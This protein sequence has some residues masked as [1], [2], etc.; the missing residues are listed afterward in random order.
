GNRQQALKT[1]QSGLDYAQ[2]CLQQGEQDKQVWQR[3]LRLQESYTAHFE[4][5]QQVNQQSF[6]LASLGFWL[7]MMAG[8]TDV[9]NNNIV[10]HNLNIHSDTNIDKP[11]FVNGIQNL[12][13]NMIQKWHDPEKNQRLF[14]SIPTET[15]LS[16]AESIYILEQAKTKQPLSE[17]YQTLENVANSPFIQKALQCR[18]LSEQ[19]YQQLALQLEQ[20]FPKKPALWQPQRK[21]Y[22][23]QQKQLHDYRVQLDMCEGLE[24]EPQ[25]QNQVNDTIQAL[26]LWLKK[27][28]KQRFPKFTNSIDDPHHALLAILFI[29]TPNPIQQWQT[30][31]CWH[32][33]NQCS[34]SLNETR[35]ESWIKQNEPDFFSWQIL[36]NI[37]PISKQALFKRLKL[38]QNLEYFEQDELIK[39]LQQLQQGNIQPL[40]QQLDN[41]WRELQEQAAELQQLLDLLHEDKDNYQIL[42]TALILGDAQTIIYQQIAQ[43]WQ[44]QGFIEQ[45]DKQFSAEILDVYQALQQRFQSATSLYETVYPE[46]ALWVEC[47]AKVHFQELLQQ[48]NPDTNQ[49]WNALERSR[50]SLRHVHFELEK[51]W[52]EN[53]GHDLWVITRK[54][55]KQVRAEVETAQSGLFDSDIPQTLFPPIQYWLQCFQTPIASIEECQQQLK[56][57]QAIIQPFIDESRQILRLL[58]LDKQSLKIYD[59][60]NSQHAQQWQKLIDQWQHNWQSVLDDER[61]NSLADDIQHWA[62]DFEHLIAIFPTP[63]GQLAWEAMPQLANKLSREISIDHWLHCPKSTTNNNN[64]VL[65]VIDT[66]AMQSAHFIPHETCLVAKHWNTQPTLI[67]QQPLALFQALQNL[68]QHRKIFISTHGVFNS[69]DPLKS[70]L[71]LLNTSNKQDETKNN[72]DLP[73]W[74][75][76]SLRLDDTELMIL[77]ACQTASTPSAASN[78]FDPISI[79]STFAAAGVNTVIATLSKIDNIA[80]LIFIDDLLELAEQHPQTPWHQLIAQ[81]QNR[82]KVKTDADIKQLSAE[83]NQMENLS[84]ANKE[85]FPKKF[86][87]KRYLDLQ[88]PENWA[89]FIVI[90][91]VERN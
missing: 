72:V 46:S 22:N 11:S 62:T 42:L 7:W 33:A 13:T 53:I 80:A 74:I 31:P 63:L 12:L 20:Q 52:Q 5:L 16:I 54:N 10:I 3:I 82:F 39:Q 34:Q 91:D 78:L 26:D 24:F 48:D 79:A 88:N 83:I 51:D 58:W 44:Q 4:M 70:G 2:N 47:W 56:P 14:D 17:L 36:M 57:K 89:N 45:K 18:A 1:F 68:Q 15:L 41:V 55:I 66:E 29:Q 49:L 81:T 23:Q 60:S 50:I 69:K 87:G 76:T 35:W 32:T 59:F 86:K 19:K 71:S 67:E 27:H 84:K 65:G 37:S 73:L 28:L 90:G 85:L 43:W 9:I 75:C 6:N 77:S 38:S 21:I 61:F 30:T 64:W 40:K 25:W 8:K